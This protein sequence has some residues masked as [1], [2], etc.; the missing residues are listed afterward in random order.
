MS[1]IMDYLKSLDRA[2]DSAGI[3]L[4]ESDDKQS[5]RLTCASPGASRAERRRQAREAYKEL[6]RR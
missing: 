6:A 1:E 3:Y 2:L 5:V 4:S